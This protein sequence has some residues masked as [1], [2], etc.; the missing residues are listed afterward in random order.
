M[1]VKTFISV[2]PERLDEKVNAALEVVGSL[3]VVDV[4]FKPIFS[5][6]DNRMFFSAMIV[7]KENI[8]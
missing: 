3:N 6:L 7:Y 8:I 5:T 2:D 4:Q 1:K